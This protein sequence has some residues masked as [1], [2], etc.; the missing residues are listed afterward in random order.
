MRARRLTACLA[1]AL[2]FMGAALVLAAGAAG[3]TSPLREALVTA[4]ADYYSTN[5]V[6]KA[7]GNTIR[8]GSGIDK[9]SPLVFEFSQSMDP[10]VVALG[11]DLAAEGGSPT[12]SATTVANDTL[13]LAPLA[14]WSPGTTRTV[15]LSFAA[16]ATGSVTAQSFTLGILDTVVYVDAAQ[17]DDLQGGTA[18]KPMKS[19]K[20]AVERAA[21]IYAKAEVHVAGGSYEVNYLLGSHIKMMPG[22]SLYGGYSPA[23]WSLRDPVAWPS[24]IQNAGSA[25]TQET[26]R[27]VDCGEG[28][29]R[30]TVL[31]GFTI[32]AGGTVAANGSAAV[33][34]K[35]SGPTISN[36]Q[37]GGGTGKNSNGVV[38]KN[39]TPLIKGNTVDGGSGTDSTGIYDWNS[40]S[41]LVIEGNTI[42]GGQGSSSRIGIYN[43]GDVQGA[44]GPVI[45][46]NSIIASDTYSGDA[47][48]IYNSN[49]D[50]LIESNLVHAGKF[51][52]G[53]MGIWDVTGS[54]TVIR[55]NEIDGG[56]SEEYALY[57]TGVAIG[58]S[59]SGES[60]TIQNNTICGGSTSSLKSGCS[61]SGIVLMQGLAADTTIIEN[62]IIFTIKGNSRTGVLVGVEGLKPKSF[63]NNDIFDCPFALYTIPSSS[64]SSTWVMTAAGFSSFPWASG[65][66]SVDPLLVLTASN[67]S[68]TGSDWR[69]GAASPV[70]GAGKAIADITLDRGGNPR[71]GALSIGAWQ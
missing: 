39:G 7:S 56:E 62:N 33:Y 14:T 50:T 27:A 34:C 1:V 19:I 69:L 24:I 5:T 48:G 43:G 54:R 66:L 32:R 57:A 58:I 52:H 47:I 3:C 20:L 63:A 11:G 60:S 17:G 30:D 31:D 18:A 53:G 12:W 46:G 61:S 6:V 21:A 67:G 35:N 8:D 2:P 29:G 25:T 9:A 44:S 36:N 38:V 45:R 65:N 42:T 70:K 15:T 51:S 64:G 13:T 40:G 37:L 68:V 26:L 55:S 23:D 16:G 4:M 10:G 22:I 59:L 28:L 71:T 41:G 49:A